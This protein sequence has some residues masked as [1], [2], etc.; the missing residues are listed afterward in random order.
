M[1]TLYI[2]LEQDIGLDSPDFVETLK[3]W[4]EGLSEEVGVNLM[5]FFGQDPADFFA[6]DDLGGVEMGARWF[7]PVEGIQT[8]D[9]L[10]EQLKSDTSSRAHRA[11]NEL[12]EM[13]ELLSLAQAKQTRF[14]IAL[15]I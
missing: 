6:E 7:E 15:D 1:P 14:H 11:R 8:I 4:F 9:R 12:L 13:R 10:V 2:T 5:R 3:E